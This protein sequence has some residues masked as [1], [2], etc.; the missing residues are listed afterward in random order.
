MLRWQRG[1]HLLLG[2]NGLLQRE[3]TTNASLLHSHLVYT[4]LVSLNYVDLH[5][6]RAGIRQRIRYAPMA[7]WETFIT[8]REWPLTARRHHECLTATFPSSLYSS[9]FSELCGLTY[10]QGRNKT[11][12]PICSDGNVGNIY[13]SARMASYSEKAPRM[14]HCYIPI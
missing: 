10:A 3:G 12:N 4:L 11:K 2:E 13:Y 8:R 6:R 7:T 9:R 14:P 1:K 5:T